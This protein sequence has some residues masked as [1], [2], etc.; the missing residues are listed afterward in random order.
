MKTITYNPETHKLVPIEPTE[1]MLLAY[2]KCVTEAGFKWCRH[3]WATMLNAAPATEE[4]PEQETHYWICGNTYPCPD[5]ETPVRLLKQPITHGEPVAY[6]YW[7]PIFD[8]DDIGN[9][10]EPA[11]DLRFGR[12]TEQNKK[13][14]EGTGYK[15]VPLY[16]SPQPTPEHI[17]AMWFAL[18]ILEQSRLTTS[19]KIIR[20]L[21]QQAIADLQSALKGTT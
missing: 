16:T 12:F 6:M 7:N 15:F 21:C 3:Q 17:K 8:R 9:G 19:N 14:Y 1:E 18:N 2:T 5:H 10:D 20:N 4:A 13:A 11:R